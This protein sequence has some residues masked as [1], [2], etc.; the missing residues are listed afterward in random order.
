MKG[1]DYD[2]ESLGLLRKEILREPSVVR[3]MKAVPVSRRNDLYLVGGALRDFCLGRKQVPDLDFV[4]AGDVEAL[5]RDVA[6]RLPA[7]LVVLDERW[8]V[9][10]L[11]CRPQG[12][13]EERITLDFNA[14][15]GQDIRE[16]LDRRDFT[17]NAMALSL[18]THPGSDPPHGWW[19]P[20]GGLEDLQ[21][22][23]LRTVRP[24]SFREDPLR[25]LRAFRLSASL[26]FQIEEGTLKI[27]ARERKR[28]HSSAGERIQDELI[29][30]FSLPGSYGTLEIMDRCGFLEALFPEIKGLKGLAQGKHH[31]LDGWSHSLESFRLME[32]GLLEG[33]SALPRWNEA[34]DVWLERPSGTRALLKMAALFHDLGKP[35]TQSRDPDGGIHFYGHERQ[36]AETV[37]ALMERIRM[38]R[39]AR[40]W[41][42]NWVRY[43]MGP[44]HMTQALRMGK[45]SERAKIRFLRRVGPDVMGVLILSLADV[46]A[47]GGSGTEAGWMR[48]YHELMDS[49]FSLCVERDAVSPDVRPLLSGRELMAELGIPP[50]PRVG[51]ILRLLGEARIQGT[52]HDRQGALTLARTLHETLPAR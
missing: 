28:I 43:H 50:G 10:R 2:P 42:R 20:R 38:G 39:V 13:G 11:I 16:D 17:C 45:L 4:T 31:H 12:A 49:L 5:S 52:I 3:V 22:H 32:A 44:V 41:I 34:V 26:G 7:R 19:D 27:I 30:L 8:G 21:G 47:S 23:T 48:S 33:R 29:R 24:D 35:S 6:D 15:Q 40:D 46:D 1:R 18:A 51:R 36:S 9:I 25:M 14:M 37:T